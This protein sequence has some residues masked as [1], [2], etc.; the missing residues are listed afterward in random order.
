M[1]YFVSY[2]VQKERNG[3]YVLFDAYSNGV[4]DEI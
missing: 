1:S 4:Q 3:S 2:P